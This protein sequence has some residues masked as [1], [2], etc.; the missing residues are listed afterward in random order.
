MRDRLAEVENRLEG[1]VRELKQLRERVDRLEAGTLVPSGDTV[2]VLASP[3]PPDAPT[4]R[5][6][7]AAGAVGL[8][9]RTLMAL[10]GA[11]LL[12]AITEAGTL[13]ALLGAAAGLAYAVWWLLLADRAAARA[14]RLSAVFHGVAA[15]TIAY[16]LIGEMTTRFGLL[17]HSAAAAFLLVFVA[18]G[19][20]LAWRHRL[21]EIAWVSGLFAVG[22][23]VVLLQVTHDLVTFTMTLLAIAA[24]VELTALRD[25]WLGLR[26]P[27]ALALDV[28]VLQTV[29]LAVRPGGLPPGYPRM[30]LPSVIVVGLAL[31]LLYLAS[32]ATR[33]LVR[34]RAVR[35][36]EVAQAAVALLV[37]F[38]GTLRVVEFR[39]AATLAVGAFGLLLGAACYRVAFA[40]IDRREGGARNFYVYTTF[41]ALLTLAG[42]QLMLAP[43][44]RALVWA[45]LG[46]AATWLGGRHQ[47]ITLRLHGVVYLGIAA[48]ASGLLGAVADGLVGSAEGPWRAITWVGFVVALFT[49]LA[50]LRLASTSRPGSPW[51]TL[52]PQAGCAILVAVIAGGLVSGAFGHVLARAPGASADAGLLGTG[53]TAVL[54]AL[55]VL[56]AWGGRRWD[57]AEL[58]WLV[59]PALAAGGL[60]LL[61]EDL[62]NGR[63]LTLFFSLAVYGGALFAT[64]RIMRSTR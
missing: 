52:L 51:N 61:L 6:P 34:S 39:G 63:P 20:G 17:G 25:R 24:L 29:L 43:E 46:L 4:P 40:F 23:T 62:P 16:P 53:R 49:A 10:G 21:G 8:V 27:V 45:G 38:G 55:A 26:W 59:Y 19:L 50:Y 54:A 42:A 44:P 5:F 31:P 14:R 11:Y 2:E 36:F 64:P 12:R 58:T 60:S 3:A 1:V 30:S 7:L 57:R 18:L 37:G 48:G 9:G 32:I 28:A 15:V 56:F 33:T 47:R 22:T 41:A 13:P 35:P